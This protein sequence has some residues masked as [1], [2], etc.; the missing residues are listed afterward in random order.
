[1]YCRFVGLYCGVKFIILSK[2]TNRINRT[3]A[4]RVVIGRVQVSV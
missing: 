4:S 2:S 1:M 3:C